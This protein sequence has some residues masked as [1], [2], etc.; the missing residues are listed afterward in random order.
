VFATCYLISKACFASLFNTGTVVVDLAQTKGLLWPKMNPPH[1]QPLPRP[2]F[3][4]DIFKKGGGS[5]SKALN[6]Y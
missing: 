6:A 1:S 4:I 3:C 5:I 2:S